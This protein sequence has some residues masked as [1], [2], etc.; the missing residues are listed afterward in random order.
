MN[1][2]KTLSK[3][4]LISTLTRNLLNTRLHLH[5]SNMSSREFQEIEIKM[6]WGHVS[7]KWWGTQ[8]VRPILGLHGWQ[9]NAGTFD[10]L[11]EHLPEH[12]GFLAIDLPGH[13]LSSRL[14]DGIFYNRIDSIFVLKTIMKEYNWDKISIIGHSL[15]ST[16]GFLF[17]SIFPDE[18]D[19]M[20]GMDML[21]PL[22]PPTDQIVK[23]LRAR[24]E[25]FII[26]D[27]RNRTKQE[28]PSYT[29]EE[30]VE[31][32]FTGYK[33]SIDKDKCHYIL[34]RN[35]RKSTKYPEKYYFSRDG[36]LKWLHF[37]IFFQELNQELASKI[38]APYM[39]LK[40]KAPYFEE[41]KHFDETLEVMKKNPKFEYYEIDGSHHCHL[42]EPEKVSGIINQFINKY[43]PA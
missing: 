22:V 16:V 26:Q 36:R 42:N 28:P 27:E 5:T 14:P 41:K 31:R 18:I 37:G 33:Q 35:L 23:G 40:F 15:S 21:K 13:G 34:D 12:I 32:L 1:A 11:A 4:S 20:I 10:T 38:N 19:M 3:Q 8:N 39:F 6:P 25:N 24:L 7:G 9:D 2:L 30:C 29:Y 43:R 17:A